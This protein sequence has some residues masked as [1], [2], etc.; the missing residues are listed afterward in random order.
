[1]RPR[2]AELHA[3][4]RRQLL[5]RATF[6][7]ACR[8]VRLLMALKRDPRQHTNSRQSAVR[9][10]GRHILDWRTAHVVWL[11]TREQARKPKAEG[12]LPPAVKRLG[13]SQKQLKS[14]H[15]SVW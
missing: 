10:P 13:G 15:Q 4:G 5:K 9:S 6:Q 14:R 12:I 3:E 1:M 2:R 8:R 11:R 7:P